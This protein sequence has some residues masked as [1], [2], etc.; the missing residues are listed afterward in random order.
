M[1]RREKESTHGQ[2]PAEAVA[3]Y[4]CQAARSYVLSRLGWCL[5]T[6]SVPLPAQSSQ[7]LES[8]FGLLTHL[9]VQF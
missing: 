5:A 7:T 2:F 9:S 3:V 1:K 4:A 6:K 8:R